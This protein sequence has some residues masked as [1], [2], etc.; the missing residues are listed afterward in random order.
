MKGKE[1]KSPFVMT[2]EGGQRKDGTGWLVMIWRAKSKI[3]NWTDHWGYCCSAFPSGW[4][5]LK[6]KK[7]IPMQFTKIY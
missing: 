1:V 5:P 2:N 3:L 7:R 4:S 6:G